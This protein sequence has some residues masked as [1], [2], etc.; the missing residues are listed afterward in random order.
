MTDDAATYT[1]A[2]TAPH[3]LD[4]AATSAAY[5]DLQWLTSTGRRRTMDVIAPHEPSR[6]PCHQFDDPPATCRRHQHNGAYRK[7]EI[8]LA[9]HNAG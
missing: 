8:T 4:T 6:R 9:L 2:P 5:A 7:A 1:A 3:H